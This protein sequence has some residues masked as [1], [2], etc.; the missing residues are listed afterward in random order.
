MLLRGGGVAG[1]PEQHV[2][3]CTCG[4]QFKRKS[5]YDRHQEVSHPDVSSSTHTC[6]QCN[7][8]FGNPSSLTMH[9]S[10]HE[11][12]SVARMTRSTSN[13][14]TVKAD[15]EVT[16]TRSRSRV[17]NT[18]LENLTSNHNNQ[19][20]HND[21]QPSNVNLPLE[22]SREETAMQVDSRWPES[23]E[24]RVEESDVGQLG[25]AERDVQAGCDVAPDAPINESDSQPALRK[26][27][28]RR[29]AN[30]I[31]K[32]L[33]TGRVY[34]EIL[35]HIEGSGDEQQQQHHHQQPAEQA[36]TEHYPAEELL[37]V[38]GRQLQ[39]AAERDMEPAMMGQPDSTSAEAMD[40]D[41]SHTLPDSLHLF[42][43]TVPKLERTD[44][45]FDSMDPNK[46]RKDCT[47]R[48]RSSLNSNKPIGAK[49]G[50]AFACYVCGKS[51]VSEKY[52]SMHISLHGTVKSADEMLIMEETLM[53]DAEVL[54]PLVESLPSL[55]PTPQLETPQTSPTLPT[56]TPPADEPMMTAQ[57][58]PKPSPVIKKVKKGIKV[59][60]DGGWT[61]SICNKTFAHNSGYK[62]HM[63]THSNER[64]YVCTICDI[65]FKEKYHLKKH[66]LFIHSNEL[67][68]KCRVCGKRF[69]DSTAVRAHE[70]IHSDA[71][72]F[73]C[74]RCNKTF[75]TS[76]CLWHHEHRSKT[77][78]VALGDIIAQEKMVR[79]RR[80][81]KADEQNHEAVIQDPMISEIKQEPPECIEPDLSSEE[82]SHEQFP[83]I[84]G[85]FKSLEADIA[86]LENIY[87]NFDNISVPMKHEKD[88]SVF[89]GQPLDTQDL[90]CQVCDKAFSD[91]AAFQ[92]HGKVHTEERPYIC[93]KCDI[94]FKMKVH[95]KKHNLYV[96][97]DQK[98]CECQHCGKRFKD[99]SAVRLHERTHSDTRPFE[100]AG[101]GKAFK[102]REN[103]WGHQH[104]GKCFIAKN[105]EADMGNPNMNGAQVSY[106]VNG[107]TAHATVDQKDMS[108][109]AYVSTSQ[110]TARAVIEN[111]QVTAH[112][113][114]ANNHVTA[115]AALINNQLT[116]HA[117]I[118]NN[119][120][121]TA[122]ATIGN[123]KLEGGNVNS[124][125]QPRMATA[126]SVNGPVHVTASI[127]TTVNGSHVPVAE[128]VHVGES[129]ENNPPPT[130]T[131]SPCPQQQQVFSPHH[132]QA[133]NIL[134]KL[135]TFREFL[136]RSG[137]AQAQR[138]P[139]SWDDNG[140]VSPPN[141]N[142]TGETKSVTANNYPALKERL[143]RSYFP[144]S[145]VSPMVS[146]PAQLT[147]AVLQAV[148]GTFATQPNTQFD[149]DRQCAASPVTASSP[150]AQNI[151]AA[152]TSPTLPAVA[153]IM[154]CAAAPQQ[155]QQQQQ[156][157]QQP[158]TIAGP[159]PSFQSTFLSKCRT[160]PPPL[161]SLRGQAGL[162][163]Q[164]DPSIPIIYWDDEADK[165]VQTWQSDAEAMFHDISDTVFTQL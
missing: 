24:Q 149:S 37:M 61:C 141:N 56:A 84:N 17:D 131:T 47:S 29:T 103:L 89:E 163:G 42:N 15:T 26:S 120:G 60:P 82:N 67:P 48:R 65:G 9:M 18:H 20:Y 6:S 90:R 124:C 44:F 83:F 43:M 154:P 91:T 156:S 32:T 36:V 30:P 27:L 55:P 10:V 95:L 147:K 96:H 19:H 5:T 143:S 102:T 112:A 150:T 127:P 86:A 104:R 139:Q 93:S 160:P 106:D 114:F 59:T 68:E 85:D 155:Q 71:R 128:P 33:L 108:A 121:I 94:G 69:K 45:D 79:K 66:N 97:S 119:Q 50:N 7:K 122:Q 41:D 22:K 111:N 2:Y 109:Q 23:V 165:P 53:S 34:D 40:D 81:F 39:Q 158:A 161:S 164:D 72:P 136:Q 8:T 157:Q 115:H 78:G 137:P 88:C 77:C 146:A 101:C 49:I 148:Q 130:T 16:M 133:F 28:R 21:A 113:S 123:I 80:K 138:S 118:I 35:D 73:A 62:N 74:R 4:K 125:S 70:R 52:L 76:E 134:N 75:K 153:S 151:Q 13:K 145:P 51:F 64:P 87:M 12:K 14:M 144:Q 132:Q 105:K 135:P 129:V 38:E 46:K 57:P 98:P 117:S 31:W 152:S 140:K 92:R 142:N 162:L 116:A 100:C 1:P 126:E 58:Q 99:S 107:I 63:R 159:I 110:V 3:S 54:A 11:S 25:S